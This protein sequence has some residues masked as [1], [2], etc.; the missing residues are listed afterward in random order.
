MNYLFLPNNYIAYQEQLKTEIFS[1]KKL[2][3]FV[4]HRNGNME[5]TKT[6]K[7]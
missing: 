1:I 2:L 6:I 3:Y 5:K 4:I 7:N